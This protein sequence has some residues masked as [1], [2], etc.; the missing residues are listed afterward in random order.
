MKRKAIL[1]D[2]DNTLIKDDGYIHEPEKVELLPGVPQ[3]LKL[4]KEAGFLLIV[5]SNQSGI[6]RGYFREDNFWAVNRKLQELLNPFGVQIDDFFFCP[7]KPSDNC[8]CRKPKVG[9]VEKAVKNWNIDLSK[10]FVI[11][12]KEIDVMLA[13]NA[14]C[15]G[16]IRVG[17]KPFENF[18]IAAK[19]VI[20]ILEEDNETLQQ[21]KERA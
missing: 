5:V 14:G 6:G 3:G 21:N 20:S 8:N 1:L 7:H 9:M 15:K 2:R 4:L 13:F 16:G 18:L 19:H 11:G 10:S 17:I 12:D